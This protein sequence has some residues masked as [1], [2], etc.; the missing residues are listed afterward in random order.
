MRHLVTGS[1]HSPA[2][3]GVSLCRPVPA[4]AIRRPLTCNT[5]VTASQP[6]WPT[7][8]RTLASV[9]P[10]L[11]LFTDQSVLGAGPDR[12]FTFCR[13]LDHA[14]AI[15]A[16]MAVRQVPGHSLLGEPLPT[17]N[18]VCSHTRRLDFYRAHDGD[19]AG[20]TTPNYHSSCCTML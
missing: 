7:G 5:L 2:A 20:A 12:R 10:L 3:D 15:H 11:S 19:D 9:L 14:D 6:A 1:P 13:T 4:A 16:V 17:A 8:A 18:I